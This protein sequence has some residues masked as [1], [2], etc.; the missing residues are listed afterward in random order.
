MCIPPWCACWYSCCCICDTPL[1]GV[2]FEKASNAT[3]LTVAW[4]LPICSC[5]WFSTSETFYGL[6]LQAVCVAQLNTLSACA[7]LCVFLAMYVIACVLAFVPLEWMDSVCNCT[8]DY[9][10]RMPLLLSRVCV[11]VYVCV[12]CPG[13]AQCRPVLLS[14]RIACVSYACV[15]VSPTTAALHAAAYTTANVA[16]MMGCLQPALC[17]AEQC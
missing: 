8:S 16:P 10:L 2:W 4:K 17:R 12:A 6:D 14:V 5:C 7:R 13:I 3:R 11:R 15:C 1:W 9:T